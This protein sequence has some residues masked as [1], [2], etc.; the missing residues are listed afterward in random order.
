MIFWKDVLALGTAVAVTAALGGIFIYRG[1][2]VRSEPL[3]YLTGE[4]TSYGLT[5]T[6][7]GA[8]RYFHLRL[9]DGRSARVGAGQSDATMVPG[10]RV[11]L[12]AWQSGEVVEG[13]LVPMDRCPI[14]R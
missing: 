10:D 3:G 4:I 6:R 9:D 7:L 8:H 2:H 11:C 5:V 14:G 12:H 1:V 13:W